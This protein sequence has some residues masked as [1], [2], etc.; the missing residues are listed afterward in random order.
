MTDILEDTARSLL[1]F[2]PRRTLL[3]E[4]VAQLVVF[5]DDAIRVEASGVGRLFPQS[6]RESA[7]A[8][9][10]DSA[11]GLKLC[12]TA[13]PFRAADDKH[14]AAP[15]PAPFA[16]TAIFILLVHEEH[17]YTPLILHCS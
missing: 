8:L 14:L 15:I 9:G 13:G 3:T 16:F 6:P 5:K 12:T 2:F 1:K 4:R 10:L 17:E 7:R 11:H